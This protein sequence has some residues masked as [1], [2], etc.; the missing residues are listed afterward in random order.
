VSPY[1]TA[2]AVGMMQAGATLPPPSP[3]GGKT[4]K[5]RVAEGAPPPCCRWECCG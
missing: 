2:E 5:K 4:G 1:F 3:L